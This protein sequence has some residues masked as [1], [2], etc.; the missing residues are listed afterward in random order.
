MITAVTCH[1]GWPC[2][3]PQ[4]RY[5]RPP[6]RPEWGFASSMAVLCHCQWNTRHGTYRTCSIILL[7]LLLGP[8]SYWYK[9]YAS[10]SSRLSVLRKHL[11]PGV[12]IIETIHSANIYI[13]HTSVDDDIKTSMK[14]FVNNSRK[15]YFV[16]STDMKPLLCATFI[17]G[18]NKSFNTLTNDIMNMIGSCDWAIYVYGGDIPLSATYHSYLS[19][20]TLY[21]PR[22]NNIVAFEYNIS[23]TDILLKHGHNMNDITS[24][25]YN[26]RIFP[27]PMLMTLL[28]PL[29]NSYTYT[30]VFDGDIS[31]SSV[32]INSLLTAIECSYHDPVLVSQPLIYENTQAYEYLNHRAWAHPRYSHVI[33]AETRFIEIQA[34]IFRSVFLEWYIENMIS[35]VIWAIHILGAGRLTHLSDGVDVHQGD[36]RPVESTEHA[37]T[38]LNAGVYIT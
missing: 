8:I 7:L 34:P 17:H 13:P 4:A 9:Q 10:R 35:R 22:N 32:D 5:H 28:T 29:I 11:N 12:S 36:C 15:R 2:Q 14:Y 19:R 37:L 25:S 27:K 21:L 3:C 38:C 20:L 23:R 33:A 1:K 24:H 16:S 31:I 26:M 30:W 18:D 6:Y